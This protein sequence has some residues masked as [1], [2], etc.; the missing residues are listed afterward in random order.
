MTARS[1]FSSLSQSPEGSAIDFDL[2]AAVTEPPALFLSQ[3][4]EGSAIDFDAAFSCD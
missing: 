4:S 2:T 3:S 1:G